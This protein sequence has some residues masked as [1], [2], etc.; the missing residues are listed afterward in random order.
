MLQDSY[1]LIDEFESM[2]RFTGSPQLPMRGD[3]V[4]QAGADNIAADVQAEHIV[5]TVEDSINRVL[6]ECDTIRKVLESRPEIL[7]NTYQNYEEF[8]SELFASEHDA[9]AAN[10][11]RH[12]EDVLTVLKHGH[13]EDVPT[14]PGHEEFVPKGH[15]I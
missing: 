4:P 3:Y 9:Q 1:R 14:E 13:Q 10:N 15:R 6:A 2:Y 8:K 5:E 11:N 12:Q 7:T